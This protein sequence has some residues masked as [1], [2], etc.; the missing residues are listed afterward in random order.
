MLD[1][2]RVYGLVGTAMHLATARQRA[3]VGLLIAFEIERTETEF[4]GL[5]R[6]LLDG[7][8]HLPTG[9]L[10]QHAWPC[11]VHRDDLQLAPRLLGHR[12]V[13]IVAGRRAFGDQIP[14][15]APVD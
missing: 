15:T 7:A 3:R 1:R 4:A 12:H 14:A 11:H 8:D 9:P 6:A 5:H 2:K 10:Q 13:A